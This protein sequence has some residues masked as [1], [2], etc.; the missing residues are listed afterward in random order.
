ME[1]TI[2]VYDRWGRR[3]ARFHEA[4]RLE[5]RRRG[6]DQASEI[7]GILPLS[8]RDIGPGYRLR[9]L[10]EGR[11][12]LEAEVRETQPAWGD[13]KKLILDRY[14][15][16][17]EIVEVYAQTGAMEG[18]GWLSRSYGNRDVASMVRDAINA[19]LG[20]IHY[21]VQHGQ[22][23]EGTTR[24]YN[25]LLD[26][27]TPENELEV[28]G[29]DAGDWVGADRI[30]S[31]GAWAK[32]GDTIAG[33]VVDGMAWPDFRLMMMDAEET[34]RNSRAM[35]LHP[36]VAFWTDDEY[37]RS[38]YK[39]KADAATAALQDYLDT[40]GIAFIELNP[41]KDGTGAYDDRIDAYGRY[42][43]LVYG[44]G[45]CYNAALVERDLAD[46][47][48]YDQG[49]YHVP[50]LALKDFY[51][52]RGEHTDSIAA[53][54]TTLSEV[55]FSGGV[56]EWIAALAYVAPGYIFEVD[57]Q[58]GLRFRPA[59]RADKVV[60]FNPR[61]HALSLGA[62]RSG[63]SNILIIQG[64]PL[65]TAFQKTW[66]RGESIDVLGPAVRFLPY[67]AISQED[68][69]AKLAEG[70]LQD[71]AYPE[72]SGRF[73]VYDGA[74]ELE[75]GQ[76]LAFRGA[77]LRRLDPALENA[78]TLGGDEEHVARVQE[79]RHR[80]TGRRVQ[81]TAFLGG[82]FRSVRHPLS[83]LIRSQER[84]EALFA[85]RLD[86]GAVGLDQGVHLD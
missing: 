36:E 4:P 59:D 54:A 35:R 37:D 13:N 14:V 64:N 40:H 61:K 17:H 80:F 84:A 15:N 70:L 45:K 62:T 51:S 66:T 28:G 74:A 65:T 9:I 29:I 71:L 23:P 3:S 72:P 79:V 32:D 11:L 83:F 68:D 69:G 24:E 57:A 53:C 86:D 55:D 49:R 73:E 56:L 31:S 26:R 82:P 27:S 77:P 12:F 75:V 81:T 5:V 16:F 39:R 63:L 20:P 50:E 48:L 58:L 25:K 1:Y 52:Y 34:T 18:N 38:G 60:V 43:G 44:G 21:Y 19:A 85:F 6:P 33:L 46:I 42:L 76:L 67:F 41:H 47:Y 30:D 10:I 22:Y 7:K 8:I 78:P 2:E